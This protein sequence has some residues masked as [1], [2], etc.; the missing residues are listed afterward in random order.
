MTCAAAL[1]T[2]VANVD[3]AVIVD[4][5][6]TGVAVVTTPAENLIEAFWKMSFCAPSVYPHFWL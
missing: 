1:V 5:S 6:W 4:F 2:S 3:D